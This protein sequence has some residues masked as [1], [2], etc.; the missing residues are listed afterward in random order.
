MAEYIVP[1]DHKGLLQ[2]IL[3]ELVR[4]RDPVATFITDTEWEERYL[5]ELERTG[6]DPAVSG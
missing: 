5:R 3:R 1:D 2:A 4:Q 6:E